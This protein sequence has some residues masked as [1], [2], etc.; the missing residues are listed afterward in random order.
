MVLLCVES[1]HLVWTSNNN[2]NG[3]WNPQDV[4]ATITFRGQQ[5]PFFFHTL[6]YLTL[7]TGN[8]RRCLL[9]PSA[10]QRSGGL[11]P[12]SR[13][14]GEWIE[15]IGTKSK[16]V[17]YSFSHL[18]CTPIHIH[19]YLIYLFK[20]TTR[21]ESHKTE[22]KRAVDLVMGLQNDTRIDEH[23]QVSEEYVC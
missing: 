19:H 1:D 11:V 14:K 10:S 15:P 2:I 18:H 22:N 21:K 8:I 3:G 16:H 9:F 5:V 13:G 20:N 12:Q 17:T 4:T 23:R 6:S 7:I